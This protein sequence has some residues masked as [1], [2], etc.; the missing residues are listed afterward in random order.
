MRAMQ[1]ARLLT[2]AC[3]LAACG[4]APH[5]TTTTT[6]TTT[7]SQPTYTP[8]PRPWAELDR[9]ERRAHMVQHVLPTA[10]DLFTSWDAERY[11]D[12]SCGTC[13]GAD[14]SARD[15]AMPNPGL[16]AVYPTGTV[17]QLQLVAE[18]TEA[19]TFMYSRL[20]PAVQTMLGASDYDPATREGFSCFSCHPRA[21]DDDPLNRPAPSP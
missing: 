18:R 15:F 6:T 4:G 12:F 2:I 3:V 21:A 17:G 19:C 14:A 8:P 9:D 10:S 16:I 5:T 20:V 7:P 1:T 13:H 11:G